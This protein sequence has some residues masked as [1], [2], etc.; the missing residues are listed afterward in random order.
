[1][2]RAYCPGC[3]RVL[4]LTEEYWY[5]RQ[6]RVLGFD[7]N[8]CGECH[9]RY[10]RNRKRQKLHGCPAELEPEPVVTPPEQIPCPV[11]DKVLPF[12]EEYWNRSTQNRSGF[13]TG[14]CSRCVAERRKELQRQAGPLPTPEPEPKIKP[15]RIKVNFR[16]S[17]RVIIKRHSR[18]Q[19]ATIV[20][21]ADRHFTARVEYPKGRSYL[22][23][24]LLADLHT[25]EISV[26]VSK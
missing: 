16:A 23:S 10:Q 7:T 15:T 5:T 13:F 20:Q 21:I 11:C 26:E 4:P 2:K 17:D 6:D 25:G 9:R 1:M 24:F 3:G 12:T 18:R 8:V 19:K 22:E 14:G